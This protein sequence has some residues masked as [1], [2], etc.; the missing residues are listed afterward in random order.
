M[1][2]SFSRPCQ[3]ISRLHTRTRCRPP[4]PLMIKTKIKQ[5]ECARTYIVVP[6]FNA[7][8]CHHQ[9]SLASCSIEDLKK[10]YYS[11][12]PALDKELPTRDTT[13]GQ[14][15]QHQHQLQ[16]QQQHQ[17]K[18]KQQNSTVASTPNINLLSWSNVFSN[19]TTATTVTTTTSSSGSHS[20]SGTM[21][22][23][24][25]NSSSAINSLKRKPKR[26]RKSCFR[27]YLQRDF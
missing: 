20:K 9:S 18:P 19:N 16:Q 10:K 24:K 14:A 11:A 26:K 13:S 17:Q 22:M 4:P 12:F 27:F 21:N 8:V 15:M 1:V 2:T 5:R 3:L 7:V 25:G 23:S 6:W